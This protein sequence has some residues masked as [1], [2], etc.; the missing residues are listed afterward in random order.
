MDHSRVSNKYR[1][2]TRRTWQRTNG[3][4]P[5]DYGT[6]ETTAPTDRT[7]WNLPIELFIRLHRRVFFIDH[8]FFS[9]IGV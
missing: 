2:E 9:S 4:H 5:A 7:N 3:K 8:L 1:D 6:R